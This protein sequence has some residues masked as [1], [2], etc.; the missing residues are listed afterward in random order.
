MHILQPNNLIVQEVI[1][2]TSTVLIKN[3]PLKTTVKIPNQYRN[4][5]TTYI[6][7]INT[8]TNL[9]AGDYMVFTFTGIWTLF[10]NATNIIEGVTS[11]LTNIPTWKATVN[12]QASTT[13]LKL[14]NF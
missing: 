1:S 14:S 9:K 11:S 5:S 13:V 6:F 2:T 8:D 3:K 4:T 7:Q 12:S 10:T